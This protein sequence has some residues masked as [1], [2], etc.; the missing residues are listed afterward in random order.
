MR[1]ASA[2]TKAITAELTQ[3]GA[4][5]RR[6]PRWQ[7][8]LWGFDLGT[9]GLCQRNCRHGGRCTSLI[10]GCRCVS[11]WGWR[12]RECSTDIDECVLRPGSGD[13]MG[14][15]ADRLITLQN[16]GCGDGDESISQCSNTPGSW[17][18]A[19]YPGTTGA[20][21]DGQPNTCAV[22]GQQ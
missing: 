11:K 21:S 19:C 1:T 4:P 9:F 2:S 20:G 16:A 7:I 17:E 12:G 15:A 14:L 18:C 22:T 8:E 10:A 5:R 13:T 6:L 3:A